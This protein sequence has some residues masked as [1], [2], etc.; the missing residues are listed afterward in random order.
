[1]ADPELKGRPLSL[2]LSLSH[3]HTYIN[4]CKVFYVHRKVFHGMTRIDLLTLS[5]LKTLYQAESLVA[6][7]GKHD[8]NE[9]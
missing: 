9:E 1:M 5:Y 2:S 4:T 7:Q 3:T 6:S 8:D